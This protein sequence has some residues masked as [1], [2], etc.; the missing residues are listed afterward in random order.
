MF[1]QYAPLLLLLLIVAVLSVVF[2]KLTFAAAVTGVLLGLLVF[3]GAGYTGIALMGGFFAWGVLVTSWQFNYKQQQG[4]AEE[5]SGRNV[6]QVVAN[7][8]VPAL[9]GL[10][11][12]LLPAKAALLQVAM[13]AAFAAAAGDTASS[14]LGNVYG[15]RFYNIL[16]FKK[17]KKGLNG[18]VSLEGTMYG[19]AGSAL[20]A[21]IYSTGFG[22]NSHILLI[23]VAGVIGNITDSILGATLERRHL[24]NNNAVNFLNTLIAAVAIIILKAVV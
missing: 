12:V 14:E 23:T 13:A 10:L 7:A 21:L 16:T 1:Y 15:K 18:V 19:V 22:I 6:G 9:A 20:I 3:A 17:D 5:K 4:L 8:G 2:K 24:L 11:A